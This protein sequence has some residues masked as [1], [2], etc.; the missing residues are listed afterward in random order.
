M[1]KLSSTEPAAQALR[2][3]IFCLFTAGLNVKPAD[4]RETDSL[5]KALGEVRWR[6]EQGG[7]GDNL[8][9]WIRRERQLIELSV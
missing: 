2:N 3:I 9:D 6:V 1:N 7:G 8:R 5:A 4:I